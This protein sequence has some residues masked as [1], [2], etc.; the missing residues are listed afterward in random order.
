MG[1]DIEGA[2]E[3][4]TVGEALGVLVGL[5]EGAAEGMTVGDALGVLLGLKEGADEGIKVGEVLGALVG[6]KEGAAVV[7][8]YVGAT[9][10]ETDGHGVAENQKR[11]TQHAMLAAGFT[12]WILGWVLRRNLSWHK[13][14]C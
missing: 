12:C 7:G 11:I 2:A 4:V 10:G 13:R 9:V 1:A 3:G 8:L 6:L 5:K 14:G